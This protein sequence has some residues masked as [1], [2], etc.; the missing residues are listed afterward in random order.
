MFRYLPWLIACALTVISVAFGQK[1][2]WL[3]PFGVIAFAL[4]L[5]GL[6]DLLQ[7]K[8]TLWRNYPIIGRV[9][10][11]A[12]ELRPFLRSYIVESATEGRPFNLEARALVCKRRFFCRTFREPSRY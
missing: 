6:Y 8:H 12:E 11:I 1:I 10:W 5:L 3:I 9:R 7:R 4:V 2:I